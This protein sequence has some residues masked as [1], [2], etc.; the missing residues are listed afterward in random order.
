MGVYLNYPYLSISQG[1]T[2]EWQYAVSLFVANAVNLM[3]AIKDT[4]RASKSALTL[5]HNY[6]PET[7]LSQFSANVPPQPL[8]IPDASVATIDNPRPSS[9]IHLPPHL[10]NIATS[11]QLPLSNEPTL[12]PQWKT[13]GESPD[14]LHNLIMEGMH[15]V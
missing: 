6:F 1:N 8:Q 9:H 2:P 5:P 11:G 14:K 13:I 15:N 12:R 7:S 4:L 10:P 3:K